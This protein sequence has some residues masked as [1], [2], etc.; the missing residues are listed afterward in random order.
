MKHTPS[1]LPISLDHYNCLPNHR[2]YSSSHAKFHWAVPKFMRLMIV[3]LA[4]LP[5]TI[6]AQEA[7][8][9][10]WEVVN[11]FRFIHDQK[12]ID[13]LRTVYAGLTD[14]TAY[15]LEREL[16]RRA[17][18]PINAQRANAKN[19]DHPN[20]AERRQCFAPY[21]G[22][23][24]RLADNNH[25][26]TCWDSEKHQYRKDGPCADYIN[27]RSHRVRVWI[28]NPE[29]LGPNAP[30]WILQPSAT[31]TPCDPAQGKRFCIEF[32]IAYDRDK[33]AEVS[34][35]AQFPG[36]TPITERNI[37][38]WDKLIVGL[39]DSFAA[40]EGNPDIPAEFTANRRETD[41]FFTRLAGHG[42]TRYPKKD[43]GNEAVWLDRRCHRSMYSYQ[44]K[45]ALQLALS[46][47]HEAITYVTFS[48][49]GAV[50][51]EIVS[52]SQKANEGGPKLKPQLLALQEVLQNGSKGPRPIDYL[53]LSTGGNDIGFADYVAYIL[54]RQGSLLKAL[55][56]IKH[57]SEKRMKENFELNKFERDLLGS[58]G[59]AG[60]YGK[61]QKALLEPSPSSKPTW[62]R[63][64]DCD[65]GP[66][67][68]VL[69]TPYPNV[70][71]DESGA[72][73]QGNRLE[74]DD[75]FG[76]DDK[77]ATK[78]ETVKRYVFE[79]I[80]SVQRQVGARFGWTLIDGNLSAYINHGF[81]AR[82]SFSPSLGEKFPLPT[83]VNDNWIGFDPRNYRAYEL[84]AR[85][86]RLPVD[87]KLTTDQEHNFLGLTVD[88]ALEDVRSNI[89]HPTAEGL[90]K[91]ADLN[92]GKINEI[93][94]GSLKS[95]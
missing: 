25:A 34:V 20:E 37:R 46:N 41:F 94:S 24:A 36:L 77:R 47:P 56:L 7:P 55:E 50:T 13:E 44:F 32:D 58:V 62:I 85:W 84:R 90:A 26:K 78:I 68:R 22:W 14:K 29:S 5:A 73:C 70:L 6:Q 49:S 60:N 64:K 3:I 21:R 71:T 30:Q 11:P 52:D 15:G 87:S 92:V 12:T 48:C 16:Q 35:T 17:D 79:Q 28:A 23:F 74:F 19:C 38:V 27:P 39:G 72:Q 4:L 86:F 89:M 59:V 2:S 93:E 91:T 69:L 54:L 65:A 76:S 18:E 31:F 83:W 40:G 61:L 51:N 57:V 67:R 95:P 8:A 88:V 82:N 9:I 1:G 10:Q 33:P 42:T 81:C 45:T 80:M 53:L 63:I 66:C 43:K 75:S